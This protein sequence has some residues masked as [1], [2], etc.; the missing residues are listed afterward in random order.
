MSRT[1]SVAARACVAALA[2][3]AQI[4]AADPDLLW[5]GDKMAVRDFVDGVLASQL[6]TDQAIGATVA[7]VRNGEVVMAQGYGIASTNP[8]EP[9]DAATLFR[10]GSISKL[11]V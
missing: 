4:A 1:G 7:V 10:I 9:V 11:F 5:L 3:A 2:F 8:R 6:A